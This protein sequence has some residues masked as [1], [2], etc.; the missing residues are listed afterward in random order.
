MKKVST[1]IALISLL[2][3]IAINT[4]TVGGLDTELRLQMTH[5]W[6]TG[7]QEVQIEPD[8]K[9]KIRGDIRFGIIGVGEKRYIAYEQG[10]SIV[11]LPGDWVGTQLHKLFPIIDEQGWRELAVSFLIFIPLNIAVVLAGFWLLKL[12]EFDDKV[13]GLASLTL[14][15]GTT[16]F[17]Y[18]QIHQHNN[19]MLLLVTLGYATVLAYFKDGKKSWLLMSGFALGGA[20]LFRTPS[21]IHVGTILVF[22]AGCQLQQSR[23][24][25]KFLTAI[26]TW[27]L[28]CLP[29]TILGRIFDFIRYGSFLASGKQVEKVQ[30]N[31]DP[32]WSGLPKLPDNYPFVNPPI[33][34]ILGPLISPAK[35]LFIYDPL[36]FPCL[37]LGAVYWRRFSPYLQWYLITAAFNLAL[38]FVLYCRFFSWGGDAAWGARYHVTSV[39]LILIPLLGFFIQEVLKARGL[40]LWLMRSLIALAVVVQFA[41]VAM[42][43]NLEVDQNRFGAPGARLQLRL[44]QRMSNIVCLANPN[45]SSRCISQL[46]PKLRRLLKGNNHLVFFPFKLQRQAQEYPRLAIM[47][48]LS[49]LVWFFVITAAIFLTLKFCFQF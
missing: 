27:L 13:S 8:L 5:A 40:K 38:H 17:H 11:M 47:A 9:P 29:L 3:L 25:K 41:S 16:V 42:P 2:W 49:L 39:Q 21:I 35:S 46:Q 30:L 14:L 15:L 48:N 12:F 26:G 32:M 33:E 44:A 31:T 6:W 28:G 20:M 23:D 37:I 36:F 22:L 24:S 19:Q 10:Q 7:T 4:A 18:A 1:Q 45:V 43:Y 34:G